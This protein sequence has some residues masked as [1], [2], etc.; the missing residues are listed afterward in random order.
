[1]I[2]QIPEVL[3]AAQI[4]ACTHMLADADWRDGRITAG[5]QSARVKANEQVAETCKAGREAGKIV[6]DAIERNTIFLSAALPRHV[7]P[8]LFN[9][10]A[11]GMAFGTHVDNAIR[12]IPGTPFRIRTDLSATLFLADPDSYAAGEL[13]IQDGDSAHSIKLPAGDLVLYPATTLHH[14]TPVTSGVRLAAFFWVQSLV[15][16]TAARDILHDMDISIQQLSAADPDNGAV[17]RLSGCYHNL[18][19][20]WTEI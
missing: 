8:P 12:T 18:V 16:D 11:S 2:I 17:L 5:P 15:K 6:L 14:V 19:R 10:Y 1:M 13:V 3:S 7:Y 20:R 9:R 4:S